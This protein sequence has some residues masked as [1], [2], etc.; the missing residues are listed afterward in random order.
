MIVEREK[1][2]IVSTGVYLPD[3]R[4]TSSEI[5]SLSGIPQDVVETKMGI[6]QKTIP[7]PDDHTCQIGVFAAEKALKKA[8]IDPLDID[9]II[10]IGEEHKEY[11]LWTA[12]IK[13][14]QE[15]GADNAWAFDVALRCS[16]T[17]MAL[18][19]A[20][21]MM[22]SDSSIRT[23]L[24]AGGYRNLDFID[25]ENPRTRFMYNL[26]AGGGAIILQK[27]FNNNEL[28]ETSLITDG[29]FSE[30][31]VVVAGGTKHP[32]T[33]DAIENRLNYLDV[34]DP[35][36]MKERLEDKSMKNFLK[37]IRYSL[38][39]SN[40]TEAEIDYLAIL[41]MK[42]S[43]HDYVLKELNLR[44]EQ[45]IYLDHYGHM[46]QIDQIL[47]LELALEQGKVNKG[48]LVV[49]VSAGIGYAWGATTI[50]WG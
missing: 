43:A 24:L 33:G 32:I 6:R 44:D 39:K 2:G 22:N 37:V 18:K 11:P 10:Y 13:L 38:E 50:R 4:M 15:I 23:V 9:L 19:V 14:Q 30:D 42:R 47:S 29:S 28:L 25:Y 31:V 12:G 7:G 20:K 3:G 48:D 1:I 5:A 46:G 36:G 45:S 49:L 26:S 21:D 35:Q 17:M 40:L 41:H 16:T 8:A 27:G 34:L